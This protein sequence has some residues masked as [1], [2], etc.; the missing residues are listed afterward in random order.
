MTGYNYALAVVERAHTS[1]TDKLA[2]CPW[3]ALRQ[4]A[5]LRRM[6]VSMTEQRARLR[7]A[8]ARLDADPEMLVEA[9]RLLASKLEAL[10]WWR[11]VSRVQALRMLDLLDR[12][13][14]EVRRG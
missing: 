12:A 8:V 11:I 6:L 13:I 5:A 1:T 9:R 10:P 14:A 2:R 3:W 4:R 7:R